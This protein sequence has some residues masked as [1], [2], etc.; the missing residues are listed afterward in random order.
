MPSDLTIATIGF[1]QKNAEQFFSLLRNSP[2]TKLIDVRLN[3]SS[4]LAGFTKQDDLTFFLREVLNW[5]YQ[6]LPELAPTKG[7]LD[8]YKKHGGDWDVY[9]REF[10]ELMDR[11]RIHQHLSPDTLANSCLLCSEHLPSQCHRRLVVEF[12]AQKWAVPIQILHLY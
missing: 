2:A 7:I 9:Q 10:L 5:E 11:R 6:H 3:N 4:Q 8:A 12:L 1:T